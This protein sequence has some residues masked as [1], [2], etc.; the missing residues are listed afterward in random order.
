M[1][2]NITQLI[3]VVFA[4]LFFLMLI[5]ALVLWRGTVNKTKWD[6]NLQSLS[7]PNCGKEAPLARK[8]RNWRQALWGG[9]TCECGTEYD[10]WGVEV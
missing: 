3:L 1:E 7:C 2:T 10:K 4:V 5:G 6:V 9:H 8:P